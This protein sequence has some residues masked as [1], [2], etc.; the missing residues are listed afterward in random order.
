MLKNLKPYCRN[1]SPPWRCWGLCVIAGRW[2]SHAFIHVNML[3]SVSD[4]NTL[5]MAHLLLILC[6]KM[7]KFN[8]AEAKGLKNEVS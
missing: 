7:M 8:C 5:M 4:F 6:L 1:L 2:P 3:D